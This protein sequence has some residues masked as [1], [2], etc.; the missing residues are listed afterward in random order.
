MM[1]NLL[2]VLSVIVLLVMHISIYGQ[3]ALTALA[4]SPLSIAITIGQ[5]A[6]KD[7][8]KVYYVQVKAIGT[9]RDLAR[10]AGFQLAIEQAVG[11]V[12]VSETE[13]KGNDLTRRDFYKYSSGFIHDFKILS[14]E[15]DGEKTILLMDVWVAES[16]I[17]DRVLNKSNASGKVDGERIAVQKET[18]VLKNSSGENIIRN[19]LKDYPVRA[20]DVSV[21]EPVTTL[22]NKRVEIHIPVDVSWAD[23]YL[24]ALID[25]IDRTKD[26]TSRSVRGRN[27][28]QNIVISYRKKNGWIDYFASYQDVEK[29]K[30]L[31]QYLIESQPHIQLSLKDKDSNVLKTFCYG[32]PQLTGSYFGDARMII[33]KDI[34]DFPKGQFVAL[35]TPYSHI[36]IY[37]DHEVSTKLKIRDIQDVG[38][39]KQIDSID[40]TV[41]SKL[42]CLG[43]DINVLNR[44]DIIEW[45]RRNPGNGKRYCPIY[46]R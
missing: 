9:D 39:L 26:G 22:I 8:K 43:G 14:E 18:V 35:E 37:G 46:A 34:A 7:Q 40:A 11:T 36:G 44:P 42:D 3:T 4:P 23:S 25:V 12:V 20:F 16:A 19:V 1:Q 28:S 33:G 41:A 2:K 5:W 32:I 13:L 38:T 45:C 21:G 30:L 29:L 6:F 24:N 15:K 31:R 17:A 10:N 27:G